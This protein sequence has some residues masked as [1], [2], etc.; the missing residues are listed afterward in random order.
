M[1]R[2]S[3]PSPCILP[4]NSRGQSEPC[5]YRRMGGR[6][7]RRAAYPVTNEEPDML[8]SSPHAEGL[9]SLFDGIKE[10][11]IERIEAL[12]G[13]EPWLLNARDERGYTPLRA[14]VWEGKEEQRELMARRLIER[15]AE[16]DLQVACT[17]NLADRVEALLAEGPERLDDMSPDGWSVMHHVGWRG[18]VEAARVLV[19]HGADVNVK[20]RNR[21][22]TPA[23]QCAAGDGGPAITRFLLE[24]GADPNA[25][26]AY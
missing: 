2:A 10:G 16:L 11:N 6:K 17:L 18:A 21:D 7:R 23:L 13:E 15:G 26:D 1:G 8:E 3:W 24:H 25:E 5:R 19:A 12:L 4:R 22:G 9:K 20:P 14:V